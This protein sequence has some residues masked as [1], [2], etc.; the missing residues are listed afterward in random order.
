MFPCITRPARIT[1]QSATLIDNII[2]NKELYGNNYS[3]IVISDLSDHMPSL[4]LLKNRKCIPIGSNKCYKRNLSE[5]RV[6]KIVELL[7]TTNL[8]A[9]AANPQHDLDTCVTMFHTHIMRLY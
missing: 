7:R 3:N 9:I 2:V 8:S 4:C 6:K 5:K 1:H